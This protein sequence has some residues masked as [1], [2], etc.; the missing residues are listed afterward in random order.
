MSDYQKCP[1]CKKWGWANT[2]TCPPAYGVRMSDCDRDEEV[3][4]YADDPEE[5]AKTYLSDRFAE[6]EYPKSATVIVNDWRANH[7]GGHEYTYEITVEAQPVFYAE[8]IS[9]AQIEQDV[10][11]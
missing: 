5:A 2:H 3:E 6:F 9:E 10:T 8:L 7:W 4:V 1:I 11:P